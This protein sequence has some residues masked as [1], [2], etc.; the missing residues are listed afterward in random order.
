VWLSSLLDLACIGIT[1]SLLPA[2]QA[3]QSIRVTGS[4]LWKRVVAAAI[5]H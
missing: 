1:T 5:P 4:G 3:L 2:A